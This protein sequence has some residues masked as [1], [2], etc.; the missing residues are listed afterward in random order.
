MAPVSPAPPPRNDTTLGIVGSEHPLRDPRDTHAAAV[1]I[2]ETNER[3]LAPEVPR[4]AQ[5]DR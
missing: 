2:W 3:H 1:N 5:V 4:V